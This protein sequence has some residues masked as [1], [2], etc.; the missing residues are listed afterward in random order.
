MEHLLLNLWMIFKSYVSLRGNLII[1]G[2]FN[3]NWLDN[4]D[5]ERR[6]L[7]NSLESFGFV[8]HIELPTYQNGNNNNVFI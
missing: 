4:S 1:V 2:D 3:I 8:Q 5:S 7:F 6:N